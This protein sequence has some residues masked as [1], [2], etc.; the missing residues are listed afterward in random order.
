MLVYEER[1][2]SSKFFL[3]ME[4]RR[5]IQARLEDLKLINKLLRIRTRFRMNSYFS[6]KLF[7]ET[8]QKTLLKTA[9][10]F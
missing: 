8:R 9:K 10:V 5:G 6:M 2:K 3:N 4:K 7:L 1:K